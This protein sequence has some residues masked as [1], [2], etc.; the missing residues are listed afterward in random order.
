MWGLSPYL[1]AHLL[2]ARHTFFW[3][4]TVIALL[5][6]CSMPLTNEHR[7]GGFLMFALVWQGFFL[8]HHYSQ[9]PETRTTQGLLLHSCYAADRLKITSCERCPTPFFGRHCRVLLSDMFW[10]LINS[11]Q[12]EQRLL[13]ILFT[14]RGVLYS[15]FKDRSCSNPFT[16]EAGQSRASPVSSPIEIQCK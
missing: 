4:K 15:F 13:F 9:T 14:F 6:A 10:E 5:L 7:N 11:L 3:S 8:N 16:T 1:T 12:S 2:R